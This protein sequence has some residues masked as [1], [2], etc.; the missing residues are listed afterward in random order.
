MTDTSKYD[1]EAIAADLT[2]ENLKTTER[3][4]I[5]PRLFQFGAVIGAIVATIVL[6]PEA[7]N[8]ENIDGHEWGLLG[9]YA[10][11]AFFFFQGRAIVNST[12]KRLDIIKKHK[13]G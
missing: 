6:L 12:N 7:I 2:E 8:P 13:I 11:S 10:A 9:A 5:V 3:I 4:M 1:L